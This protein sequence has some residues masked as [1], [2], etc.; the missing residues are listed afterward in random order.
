M[1]GD[2]CSSPLAMGACR[3]LMSRI[4]HARSTCTVIPLSSF[5]TPSGRHGSLALQGNRAYVATGS[6]PAAHR[7]TSPTPGPRRFG[8]RE[9]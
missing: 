3:S 6:S 8:R 1:A 4:R 2:L 7:L 5:L 9:F